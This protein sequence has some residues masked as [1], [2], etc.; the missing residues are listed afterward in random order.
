[1]SPRSAALVR[2]VAAAVFLGFALRSAFA[3]DDAFISFRYAANWAEW[4]EPVYNAGE[5]V[6]GYS[7]FLWVCLLR[8]LA[9]LGVALPAAATWISLACALATLALVERHLRRDLELAPA[10]SAAGVFLLACFPPFQVWATGGLESAAHA[11]LLFATYRLLA[12]PGEDRRLGLLAGLTGLGLALVRVEGVAWVAAALAGAWFASRAH[13]PRFGVRAV[14]CLAP[15]LVGFALFLLWRHATYGAWLA[16]TASAKGGTNAAVLAR[17]ART[18]A[19]Y[20]LLFVAPVVALLAVPLAAPRRKGAALGA[21][22]VFAAFLLF[23]V[24][25]GGDWM[26][27]FR[28]LAPASPFV[29]VLAA[30]ALERAGRA[31]VPL[32]AALAA[33]QLLPVF[34]VHLVPRPLR[35]ALYFR[36]FRVGYET[37]WGRWERSVENGEAFERIGRALGAATEPEDSITLGPIGAIGY[38]SGLHVLDRNGLV[39]PEVATL[40]VEL[41]AKTAGHDRRVPRSF[42]LDREPTY[43]EVLAWPS[44]MTAEVWPG[45]E[46]A[47]RDLAS[48]VFSDP[49]DRVLAETCVARE[50]ELP[51]TLA[52]GT[53]VLVLERV[54]DAALARS[55]WSSLGAD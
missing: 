15:V 14:A 44:P 53:H 42:F 39:E 7:N 16:N 54:E 9:E 48:F 24:V 23:N 4:G 22:V 5:F 27:M 25:V 10:A 8:G 38:Y 3:I 36:T 19:S 47:A 32:A 51:E 26:P 2:V 49:A 12:A 50:L 29:A 17:G 33:L 41:G 1:M 31:L 34:D 20:A 21:L 55:F 46:R 30:L 6:E 35:E 37:E 45:F 40:D 18:V 43:F 11:L 52:P 13:R 28:L